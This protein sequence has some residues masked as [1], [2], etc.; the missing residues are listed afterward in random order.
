[1]SEIQDRPRILRAIKKCLSD[2][3]EHIQ[4]AMDALDE[5]GKG[6]LGAGMTSLVGGFAMKDPKENYRSA[7]IDLDSTEKALAP[8]M[9]RISNGMVSE[10][11]FQDKK[12]ILLLTD[13]SQFEYQSIVARL[14]EREGRESVWYR[15]REL[16]QKVE[17]IFKL[18]APE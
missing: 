10:S 9:K 18:V 3:Y 2:A 7:L 4:D 11:H 16:G 5:I 17:A 14:S 13:L 8:L 1:L 6:S 12:A 15:L